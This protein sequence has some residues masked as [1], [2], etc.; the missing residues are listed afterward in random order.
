MS[1]AERLTAKPILQLPLRLSERRLLLVGLDLAALGIALQLALV[2]RSIAAFGWS[3]M[4]AQPLWFIVLAVIWVAMAHTFDAYEP[5]VTGRF[6]ASMRAVVKAALCTAVLY[7]LVPYVTPPLP[8]S[9][10][11][12][13]SFP[14]FIAF[15][16]LTERC[17]YWVIFPHSAFQRNVLVVGAGRAGCTMVSAL[18][19]GVETGYRVAGFVDDAPD[20]Q[21]AAIPV[22]AMPGS[23]AAD[24]RHSSAIIRV[25]GDRNALA[26]LISRHRISALIVAITHDIDSGLLQLLLDCMEQGVEV[27][28]MPVLYERLTG[29]VPVEHVAENWYISMPLEPL[30]GSALWQFTKRLMDIILSLAGL[31]VLLSL[32]P[33]I[34]AAIYFDSRGPILYVQRRVGRGGR[35]FDAYKFRS[36]VPNA[37]NGQAVWAAERDPRVTRVGRILRSTHIDEFP[38]FLNVLRGDMS[39]VGPRPER[40]EIAETLAVEIPFYRLRHAV[41]P[42]MGGWGLVRQGYAGT[43]EDALMRLQYDLYYIKHQSL[44]LDIEILLKTIAHALALRG[45]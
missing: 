6:E 36:M 29:R 17:M 40:P 13:I 32:L 24:R 27:I 5:W 43:Q 9:R 8:T 10:W 42:G 38:Q 31:V 22:P 30:H 45:R 26:G 39:A 28:P 1:L 18:A 12:L 44:W 21:G 15:T 41:K 25:L 14:L 33:L 37:E 20:K 2:A 16:L 3:Q 4:A 19:Q 11:A 23:T 34:A 35:H 7:L